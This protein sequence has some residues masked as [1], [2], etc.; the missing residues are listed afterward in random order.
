[1]KKK[2]LIKCKKPNNKPVATIGQKTSNK[3]DVFSLQK[4]PESIRLKL[5]EHNRWHWKCCCNYSAKVRLNVVAVAVVAASVEFETATVAVV[6]EHLLSFVLYFVAD[7]VLELDSLEN[8]AMCRNIVCVVDGVV[9]D[10][11]L[12]MTVAELCGCNTAL[13]LM[14][15]S[16]SINSASVVSSFSESSPSQDIGRV[17]SVSESE[18]SALV[19]G[20]RMPKPVVQFATRAPLN[21]AICCS[22]RSNNGRGSI[23][24]NMIAH[25]DRQLK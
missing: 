24:H 25:I 12:L 7:L 23:G 6:F 22:S 4:Q 10:T 19:T 18:S 15:V 8:S 16:V 20:I 13:L 21:I 11:S 9:V 1:M 3:I 2:L 14:V 5:P 17:N